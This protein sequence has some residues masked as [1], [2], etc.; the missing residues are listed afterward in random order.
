MINMIVDFNA[1]SK[2]WCSID[3]ISFEGSE[4]DFLTSQFGLSQIIEPTHILDKSRS[5]IDLIFTSQPVVIDSGVH[6]SLHSNCHHQIIYAKFDLKIIYPWH[7]K[8]V[9]SDHIKRAIDI[10]DWESALNHI[11]VNDQVSVFSSAILNIVSNFIPNET[12]ACDDRDPPWINSFIKYLIHA[13][14]S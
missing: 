4:L 1:K 13:K 5:C 2:G 9:S 3:I 8:H 14:D 10:F 12:C 6:A 11:D 7:F